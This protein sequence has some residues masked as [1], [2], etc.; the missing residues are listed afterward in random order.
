MN[1]CLVRTLYKLA[2]FPQIVNQHHMV[3]IITIRNYVFLLK[4]IENLV[5]IKYQVPSFVVKKLSP[6]QLGCKYDTEKCQSLSLFQ[7]GEA[8]PYHNGCFLRIESLPLYT[9]M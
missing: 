8:Y 5:Q 9:I 2:T 1:E 4:C 6:L 3:I 7:I